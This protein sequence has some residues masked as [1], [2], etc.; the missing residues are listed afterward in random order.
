MAAQEKTIWDQVEDGLEDLGADILK[1][2][3]E[4]INKRTRLLEN[5]IKV[6]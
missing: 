3:T 4:D 5:D 1:C 6:S 2:S